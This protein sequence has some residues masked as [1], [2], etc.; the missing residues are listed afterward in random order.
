MSELE[1][2]LP[3]RVEREGGDAKPARRLRRVRGRVYYEERRKR[4]AELS[5][6]ISRKGFVVTQTVSTD[7]KQATF[8]FREMVNQYRLARGLAPLPLEDK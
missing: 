6:F 5:G 8:S 3:D 4:V 1:N 2:R 7:Q